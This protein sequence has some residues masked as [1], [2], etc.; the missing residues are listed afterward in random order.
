MVERAI[1]AERARRRG[2][3]RLLH[4]GYRAEHAVGSGRRALRGACRYPAVLCGR[5]GRGSRLPPRPRTRS[6]DRRRPGPRVPGDHREWTSKWAAHRNVHRKRLRAC[7]RQDPTHSHIRRSSGSPRSRGAGRV[8]QTHDSL[9]RCGGAGPA[10]TGTSGNRPGIT[11][12]RSEQLAALDALP[13]RLL[14]P[15]RARVYRCVWS[16]VR[17]DR[18][19]RQKLSGLSAA[20]GG[21]ASPNLETAGSRPS[22][23]A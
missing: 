17:S 13:R 21:P 10:A 20:R 22:R 4:A 14:R 23:L 1:T 15:Q 19:V 3:P 2:L 7:Q 12:S 5:R 18:S 8:A 11:A 16:P 9:P 6:R